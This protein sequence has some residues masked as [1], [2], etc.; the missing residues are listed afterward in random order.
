[1]REVDEIYFRL[2]CKHSVALEILTWHEYLVNAAGRTKDTDLT[3]PLATEQN[4]VPDI[5]DSAGEDDETIGC[6]ERAMP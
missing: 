1:M 6:N 2:L 3:E 4:Q 5:W